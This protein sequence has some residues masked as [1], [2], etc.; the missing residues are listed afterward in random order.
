MKIEDKLIDIYLTEYS[1]LINHISTRVNLRHNIIRFSV[2]VSTGFIGITGWIYQYN[3]KELS[4]ILL[5]IPFLFYTLA[6]LML[7]NDF[8]IIGL[9]AYIYYVLRP[10]IKEQLGLTS[11]DVLNYDKLLHYIRELRTYRIAIISRY[12]VL[13]L[14]ALGSLFVYWKLFFNKQDIYS[15]VLLSVNLAI[16]LLLI[17]IVSLNL[18]NPPALPNKLKMLVNNLGNVNNVEEN[19]NE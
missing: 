13:I 7:E 12:G 9:T 19:K 15:I 2:L 6:L 11:E 1:S 3:A 16:V 4:I 10:R 17:L 8:I 18:K 14:P 5:I